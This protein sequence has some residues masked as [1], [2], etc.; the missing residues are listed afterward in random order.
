MR[1]VRRLLG[2]IFFGPWAFVVW[3]LG[4]A[5]Y[6]FVQGQPWLGVTMLVALPAGLLLIW[7][8]GG[9]PA[10][11]GPPLAELERQ[12]QADLKRI[13]GRHAHDP[14]IRDA[15]GLPPEAPE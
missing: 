9:G 14:E 2:R 6:D 13:L 12:Y 15:F 11:P 3:C 7:A 10:P 8:W 1:R 5:T 4:W